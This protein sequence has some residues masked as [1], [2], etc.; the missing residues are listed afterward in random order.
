MAK[1]KGLRKAKHGKRHSRKKHGGEI[2]QTMDDII[3]KKTELE[4]ELEDRHNNLEELQVLQYLKIY[5]ELKPR[6][7]RLFEMTN[8]VAYDEFVRYRNMIDDNKHNPIVNYKTLSNADLKKEIKSLEN[9][10]RGKVG[11]KE[12]EDIQK[13]LNTL[14]TTC[15]NKVN[16]DVEKKNSENIT[17]RYTTT[18]QN[19][20]EDSIKSDGDFKC[21]AN[22]PGEIIVKDKNA[23]DN[24]ELRTVDAVNG[25]VPLNIETQQKFQKNYNSNVQEKEK[26]KVPEWKKEPGI[27]PDHAFTEDVEKSIEIQREKDERKFLKTWT[28]SPAYKLDDG[29]PNWKKIYNFFNSEGLDKPIVLTE[30]YNKFVKDRCSHEQYSMEQIENTKCKLNN[31]QKKKML[32]AI[33]PDKNPG[34]KCELV[35]KEKQSKFNS[36]E[37]TT[38][39]KKKRSK[40]TQRKIKRKHRASSRH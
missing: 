38:G 37:C 36:I 35:S 13:E 17:T 23:T 10:L 31:V 40:K 19:T 39:G 7:E 12:K 33:H 20:T 30:E 6:S 21:N 8:K 4:K 27:V 24:G 5:S 16:V 26:E 11:N 32:L 14:K 28:D 15:P 2:F 3:N 18:F 22:G 29:S 25:I 1:T 9:D 34:K